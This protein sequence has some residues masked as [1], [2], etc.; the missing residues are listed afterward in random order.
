M[1]LL[2]ALVFFL[3]KR[4]EAGKYRWL[5][6]ILCATACGLRFFRSILFK[7]YTG[8]MKVPGVDVPAIHQELTHYHSLVDSAMKQMILAMLFCIAWRLAAPKT[9]N[10]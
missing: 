8:K 9:S 6:V 1:I 4:E 2:T 7:F 3:T 5:P 10:N